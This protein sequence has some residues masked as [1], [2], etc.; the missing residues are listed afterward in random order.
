MGV[1]LSQDTGGAPFA[2]AQHVAGGGGGPYSH[3]QVNVVGL[4]SKTRGWS[5]RFP[6]IPP[7]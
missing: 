5:S 6:D 2:S 7:L 3:E 1:A 4:H